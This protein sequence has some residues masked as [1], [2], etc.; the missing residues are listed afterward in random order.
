M[1]RAAPTEDS[2]FSHQQLLAP[3]ALVSMLWWDLKLQIR[4]G[5]YTVYAVMVVLYVIGVLSL[6]ASARDTAVTLV[7]LSDPVFI[8]F[9]FTG[10]L[11]LFEKRDG[12]LDALVVSPLSSRAYLASKTLSLTLLGV[13]TSFVIA[14]SVHGLQFDI[15][16]YLLGIVLSSMLFVLI[17]I[18]A[19]ARFN[20]INA[21]MMAAVV[22]LLPTALP[23]L[24]F[25]G[26]THPVLYLIPTEATLLL[27][28][29]AFGAFDPLPMW[30]LAY[31]VGY[32][33]LWIGGTAVLADRAFERHIVQGVTAG[34]NSGSTVSVPDI[35]QMFEGRRFGTIGSLALSD[36]R[37]WLRDPLLT[38]ILFLPF[39]Y[40]LLARFVTPVITDWLAPGFDLVPYYPMVFGLFFSM[41][42]F[43]VGMAI[44]LLIL[45]EK[46]ENILAGLWTTPLTS[47][48]YLTYR[49]IS[50][51]LIC[52]VSTVLVAP[53]IGLVDLPTR[54]V[55]LTAAV[56][57]LWAICVAF[58]ISSFA[59]NTVEGIAVSKFVAFSLM[60]PLFAIAVV[61]EPLQFLAGAVPI[62]WP[63]KVIVD[64]AV[65]ASSVTMLVYI[66]IGIV[67]HALYIGVFV[68]RFDPSV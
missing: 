39:L 41:P 52:F 10:A 20:T 54:V 36:L 47:R 28:G 14:V 53:L 7:I 63:L 40:A 11:V 66:A 34:E 4:Y 50:V 16:L 43:T 46:E 57:S 17:G 3:G 65:G 12:V 67:T 13:L 23:L 8:G 26:M 6:P 19:V 58:I 48:G 37:N 2:E 61:P 38:Y 49:G 62:Y 9:L 35:T 68:Q 18:V 56:G 25:I 60:I 45:E 33:L 5:F 31:A 32:L 21:Y 15:G 42:S 55:L 24:E 30:E 29:S 22:Y 51:V 44:G 64:G 59:S 27:L 1:N